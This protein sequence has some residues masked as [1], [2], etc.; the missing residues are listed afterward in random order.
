MSNGGDEG[1]VDVSRSP[2]FDLRFFRAA[3]RSANELPGL[4]P[5]WLEEGLS[6]GA[7]RALEFFRKG[8]V[9]CTVSMLLLFYIWIF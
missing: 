9:W 6:S 8:Q 1:V 2:V 3:V 4:G 5:R 7:D